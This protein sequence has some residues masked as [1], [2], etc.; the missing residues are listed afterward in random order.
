MNSEADIAKPDFSELGDGWQITY[1]PTP[2]AKRG[3]VK[4]EYFAGIL[5]D[6]RASL[7]GAFPESGISAKQALANLKAELIRQVR[8]HTEIIDIIQ[9]ALRDIDR[10]PTKIAP[11]DNLFIWNRYVE[12]LWFGGIYLGQ[13]SSLNNP[14]VS[15]ELNCYGDADTNGPN[16]TMVFRSG[17]YGPDTLENMQKLANQLALEF[18]ADNGWVRRPEPTLDAEFVEDWKRSLD[19]VV[20]DIWHE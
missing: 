12:R 20:K 19:G 3:T 10:P 16:W 2:T 14:I 17:R 1:D 7:A 15:V 6:Y 8:A 18:M 5:P 11:V 9:S 13:P 4:V